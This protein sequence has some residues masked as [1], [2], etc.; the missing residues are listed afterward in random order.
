[1]KQDEA[2]R[3]PWTHDWKNPSKV[4]PSERIVNLSRAIYYDRETVDLV[5]DIL[6]SS[7]NVH[8]YADDWVVYNAICK[9]WDLDIDTVSVGFGS[10]DVM[11]RCFTTVDVDHWYVV[12]PHYQL[13]PVL[14]ALNNRRF[15]YISIDQAFEITDKNS[16]L[17]LANPGSV[18][19][20]C[21]DIS[22]LHKQYKNLIADEVYADF[23]PNHT[24]I[25]SVPE[26]TVVLR[27][28]S[29]TLGIAGFRCGFAVA[30]KKITDQLQSVR[31]LI[32]VTKPAELTVPVLLPRVNKVIDNLN[33]VK[34]TLEEKFPCKPSKT[35]YMLF[36]EP[37]EYTERFGARQAGG[38]YR[39]ALADWKTLNDTTN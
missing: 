37:N 35:L 26:N 38:F 8:D 23:Y 28:L 22:E 12:T 39:I 36:K 11:D 13:A 15:T 20:E 19:G 18:S 21:I 29:K 30:S 16:G 5:G 34:K 9:H 32:I 2:I 17:Y 25:H 4:H 10:S 6:G 31:S 7:K 27:S 33:S 14:I 24:L 3:P 1:M